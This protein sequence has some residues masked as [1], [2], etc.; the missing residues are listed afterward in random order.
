MLV[1]LSADEIHALARCCNHA[2][3]CDAYTFEKKI[4]KT[5]ADKLDDLSRDVT[6]ERFRELSEDVKKSVSTSLKQM[7]DDLKTD[8]E[9]YENAENMIKAI[10]AAL[11]A[12]EKVVSLFA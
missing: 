8:A 10:T 6:V 2:R 1:N 7:A 12:L 3:N 9:Q 5:L 4:L 11:A